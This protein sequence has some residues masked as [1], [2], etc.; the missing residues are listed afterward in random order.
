MDIRLP[1][2]QVLGVE[3]RGGGTPILFV[4]GFP[5]NRTMWAGQIEEL[6]HSFRVIAP[7]LR[8]F[9]E[10][11]GDSDVLTMEQFADDL[12][13]L[14]E[15]LHITEPVCLCGL[16][17]GGYIAF[18]FAEKY[19]ARLRALILCDTRSGPDSEEAVKNRRQLAEKVL[20]SGPETAVTT[21]L[22]KLVSERTRTDRPEIVERLREMILQTDRRSIA[23]A[24][25][26]MAARPDS[27]PL[28]GEIHVPALL[29]CGTEDV[30][31]PPGVMQEMAERLPHAQFVEIPETG[32]MAPLE[33][34][35]AVNREIRRFLDSLQRH[36]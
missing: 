21:M 8:G 16:S 34:P 7:D 32:H 22:P 17:M 23:A 36:V 33:D 29:L 27:T 18:R 14:L 1:D 10:S 2:E 31:T 13:A 12:N 4:H 9:G 5:L 19:A 24:L 6:A 20:R 26:G 11:G 25:H 30:L 35:A 15:A 3:D 28:L